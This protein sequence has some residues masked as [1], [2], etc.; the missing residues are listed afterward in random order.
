MTAL[1]RMKN[2]LTVVAT[3][4]QMIKTAFDLDPELPCH[5]AEMITGISQNRRR[6]TDF[7][8]DFRATN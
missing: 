2:I 1:A 5:I 4:D 7:H 8:T 6:D 3:G